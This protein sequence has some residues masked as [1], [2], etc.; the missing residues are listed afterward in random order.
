MSKKSTSQ[1][2]QQSADSHR[3]FPS[4]AA[5]R[6]TIESV[7]IAFILA[8]LFRTFEAEAFVIPTGSMAPTL[9]GRHKDLVC[10]MCGYPYQL[11]ASSEVTAEGARIV[12]RNGRPQRIAAGTCPMCR[13]TN[14]DL[15]DDPS[16]SGDRILVGKLIYQFREPQRWD[17]IVF[18]FPGDPPTV[19]AHKRGDSRINF[20]KRLV[21]LPGETIRI[22]DGDVWIR[23]GGPDN[24]F[25][26][27][28]KP[29]EKLLA[30]LNPV[31]DNRYMPRIA[32][33]GWPERWRPD[34]PAIAHGAWKCDDYMTFRTDGTAGGEN[35][36][37]YEHRVPGFRQWR[38]LLAGFE[39]A[40][41][42][43][44]PRLI[45][46]FLAYDTSREAGESPAPPPAGFGGHWV[47][48]LALE[49][50][51]DLLGEQGELIFE[52]CKGGRRFHCRLD[53]STGRATLSISGDDMDHFH[54]AADTPLRGPGSHR[55]RFGNCDNQLLLWV[56]KEL[57]VFDSTTEYKEDLDNTLPEESDLRPAGVASVGAAFQI[58]GLRLLRD[59]YYMAVEGDAD[60]QRQYDVKTLPNDGMF[61][62]NKRSH[63]VRYVEFSLGP[64][65]F[66]VLGDNSARSKDGRLWGAHNHF[67]PRE[68]LIGKALF[69]YWPH[70]WDRIPYVGIPLPYFPNFKDMG[71]VK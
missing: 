16:Y 7:V 61:R 48:D 27:E 12:D 59:I 23:R 70:S 19:G 47:G 62:V 57:V 29:P 13:Y 60:S 68:L 49:C 51:V 55:V 50:T 8:F 1:P 11:S 5:V 20:I 54:P 30:M 64:D 36:L 63:G 9:M 10:P 52:L 4:S 45:T 35:W 41:E 3:R 32:E 43:V 65:Q 40:A 71:L 24:D 31:F 44:E 46:D 15:D 17:V 18:K 22:R 21:G 58:G 25:H 56:D 39:A 37:R 2:K 33:L 14:T 66:F 42:E 34:D 6:E 28:R 53:V 38:A 26:L 67:V 69:I